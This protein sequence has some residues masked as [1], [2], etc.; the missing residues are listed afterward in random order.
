[1]RKSAMPPVRKD[2]A[3]NMSEVQFSIEKAQPP[4]QINAFIIEA[5]GKT[6]P[7]A[8]GTSNRRVTI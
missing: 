7:S 3:G 5:T 6:S 4:L 1:M 8:I 2:L